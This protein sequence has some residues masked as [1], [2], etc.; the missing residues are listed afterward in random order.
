MQT[1]L[2]FLTVWA[3]PAL[4]LIPTSARQT[5]EKEAH[6]PRHGKARSARIQAYPVPSRWVCAPRALLSARMRPARRLAFLPG[7]FLRL[8]CAPWRR[9]E[10]TS[11]WALGPAV[12][13]VLSASVRAP[14]EARRMGS[15]DADRGLQSSKAHKQT[16]LEHFSGERSGRRRQRADYAAPIISLQI[17][18]GAHVSGFFY[19]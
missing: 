6:A 2:E 8:C 4:A 3:S 14:A 10:A 19:K 13:R 11:P 5:P 16:R 18:E 9:P 17:C 12:T 15:E 7:L 1:V